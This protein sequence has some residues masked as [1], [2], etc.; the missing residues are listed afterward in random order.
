MQHP[1]RSFTALEGPGP[2]VL[3]NCISVSIRFVIII[4]V[5][6]DASDLHLTVFYNDRQA[7][8]PVFRFIID[9]VLD[10]SDRFRIT[11]L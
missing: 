2:V 7:V 4:F 11:A 5:D 9:P 1:L 6:R 8:R 3:V 10:P